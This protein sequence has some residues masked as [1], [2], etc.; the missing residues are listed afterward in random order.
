MDQL[1]CVAR[2]APEQFHL[3]HYIGFGNHHH[4]TRPGT[5]VMA[6]SFTGRQPEPQLSAIAFEKRASLK[7]YSVDHSGTN[8]WC[9]AF[10]S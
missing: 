7:Q 6:G 2:F 3:V 5:G 1:E 4:E 9:Q 8:T 10:L